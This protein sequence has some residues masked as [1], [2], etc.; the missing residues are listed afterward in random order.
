MAQHEVVIERYFKKNKERE[1]IV[2]H[3]TNRAELPILAQSILHIEKNKDLKFLETVLSRIRRCHF[4]NLE[5]AFPRERI[6][7][8][9][10][11]FFSLHEREHD[12][13]KAINYIK[14]QKLIV[15]NMRR[16]YLNDMSFSE[17]SGGAK[18][19]KSSVKKVPSV[20]LYLG[21]LGST[22]S[23][24][25]QIA[26]RMI[27]SIVTEPPE[28]AREHDLVNSVKKCVE[29]LLK[30][31][32]SNNTRQKKRDY[33]V[34][35]YGSYTSYL[36][37]NN[38]EYDD[39]DIY[40]TKSYIFLNMIL[41]VFFVLT[42][43]DEHI[44][45]YNIPL[46]PFLTP[47]RFR[48]QNILDCIYID[49]Y[50]LRRMIKTVIVDSV[51]IVHPLH[52]MFNN[53]RMANELDRKKKL[54]G[55]LERYNLA[56]SSLLRWCESK[57]EIDLSKVDYNIDMD[58]FLSKFTV[59]SDKSVVSMDLD[60]FF[61]KRSPG[62]PRYFVFIIVHEP[63]KFVQ[64]IHEYVIRHWNIR[65]S[66][67]AFSFFNELFFRVD[68]P[69]TDRGYTTSQNEDMV[70]DEG[71]RGGAAGGPYLRPVPPI[72][73]VDHKNVSLAPDTV[74]GTSYSLTMYFDEN[75][76][77]KKRSATA[78][79]ASVAQYCMLHDH[80]DEARELACPILS[81]MHN[82]EE[83]MENAYHI[84]RYKIKS[85]DHKRMSLFEGEFKNM[86]RGRVDDDIE[87]PESPYLPSVRYFAK[88][89]DRLKFT[90]LQ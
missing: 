26:S 16:G 7:N 84:E 83:S 50:I 40:H 71:G 61:T 48:G 14:F 9:L 18:R 29:G 1:N 37:N 76:R 57:K 63:V 56:W 80:I 49:D 47:L 21:A 6:A 35:S 39:I 8:R 79:L 36:I 86:G 64:Y 25:S 11:E 42:S 34:V 51:R 10:H 41:F 17:Y 46:V 85:K 73:K 55:S 44:D 72:V 68:S 22:P 20:G 43:I 89:I 52:Q 15:S 33:L 13:Y 19:M 4:D 77:L 30:C 62:S 24:A 88:M 45:F 78:L 54:A 58:S 82:V 38:V 32:L 53:I 66:N 31:T 81:A 67:Y 27:K 70:D 28:T 60:S 87:I 75:N 90:W 69:K 3:I 5:Y 59:S 2:R 12:P 74:V 23:L 65:I